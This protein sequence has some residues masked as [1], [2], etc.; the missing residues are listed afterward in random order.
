MCGGQGRDRTAGLPILTQAGSLPKGVA[1]IAQF[2]VDLALVG[3]L[4][5]LIGGFLPHVREPLPLVG[6]RVPEVGA[7]VPIAGRSLLALQ[8][9]LPVYGLGV[10]LVRIHV[11]E[12]RL[13][14]PFLQLDF[15][16]VSVS[17]A[18]A[19]G[20]FAFGHE[21]FTLVDAVLTVDELR[22][23]VL[24]TPH[25]VHGRNHGATVDPRGSA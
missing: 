18:Y 5:P 6:F 2:G 17:V 15:P 14:G 11:A 12:V 20:G 1:P 19:G 21:L 22:I 23:P 13:G 24:V 4:V 16:L 8:V 9:P 25:V 10:A 7:L 3:G